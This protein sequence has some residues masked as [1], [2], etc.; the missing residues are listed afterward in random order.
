MAEDREIIYKLLVEYD[1]TDLHGW[2]V[3][4]DDETVQHLIESALEVLLKSR[5]SLVGSGRTD[6][7]VHALGRLLP[8]IR[9]AALPGDP[10]AS[11]SP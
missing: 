9:R 10:V 8:R 5:P 6:A 11:D 4:P 1:G 7:G 3:Q 2:Q